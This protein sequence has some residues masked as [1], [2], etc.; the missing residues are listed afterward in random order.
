MDSSRNQVLTRG[1]M[2]FITDQR[3]DT[4]SDLHMAQ[5]NSEQMEE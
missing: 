4:E 3:N 1:Q 2:F 5:V